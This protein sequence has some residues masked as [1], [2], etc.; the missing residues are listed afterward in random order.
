MTFTYSST[1]VTS[2]RAK[3][4]RTI[5]DTVENSGP[6]PGGSNFSD[7]ELDEFIDEEGSWQRAVALSFEALAAAWATEFDFE[8]D[9]LNASRAKVAERYQ[10][11]AKDW[12]DRYG[13]DYAGPTIV[14][15]RKVDAYS[16]DVDHSETDQGGEFSSER[17]YVFKILR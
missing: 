15:F 17:D 8:A 5:N 6:L 7:E 1:S 12:R 11:M 3:V 2:D 10:A 16:D 13:G 14:P 4:R 9:G